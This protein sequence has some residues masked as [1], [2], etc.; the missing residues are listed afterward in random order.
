MSPAPPLNRPWTEADVFTA[1]ELLT[2][3]LRL[4]DIANWLFRP[5]GE[6]DLML[7][8]GMGR[9][10]SDAAWL[11]NLVTGRKLELDASINARDIP[12]L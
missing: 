2:R 7:W 8:G 6:V 9:T 12:Q 3:N 5:L 1:R 11:M 4:A 10:A